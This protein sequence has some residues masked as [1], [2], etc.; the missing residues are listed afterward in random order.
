[1][2]MIKGLKLV[3]WHQYHVNGRKKGK[4]EGKRG[5]EEQKREGEGVET[6]WKEKEEEGIGIVKESVVEKEQR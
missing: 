3:T 5:R 4:R 1:M 2:F 6:G